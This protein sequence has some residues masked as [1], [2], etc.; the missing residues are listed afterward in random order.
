MSINNLTAKGLPEPADCSL[1]DQ[2]LLKSV[3]L[4]LNSRDVDLAIR[5]GI[6]QTKV[7]S[8]IHKWVDTL[9]N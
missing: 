2:Y 9:Y 5:F 6:S 1:F 3:K 4:R 8:Y 7:L